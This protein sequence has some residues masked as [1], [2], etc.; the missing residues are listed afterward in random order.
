MPYFFLEKFFW[1]SQRGSQHCYLRY[2][3]DFRYRLTPDLSRCTANYPRIPRGTE[4]RAQ[5][6]S[7]RSSHC[8]S[9]NI[10]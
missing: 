9:D 8:R 6:W 7:S 5:V 2:L 3:S 10:L 4:I 1:S